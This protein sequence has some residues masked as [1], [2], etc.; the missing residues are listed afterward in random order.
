MLTGQARQAGDTVNAV[1]DNALVT[2][3]RFPSLT[4][5]LPLGPTTYYFRN[6]FEFDGDPERATLLLSPLADDGAVYYL[7]GVEIY[8]QNMPLGAVTSSTSAIRTFVA[9]SSSP[10]F[11]LSL[12]VWIL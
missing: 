2:Q 3:S 8:R 4:T 10:S 7:N 5:E 12:S 9:S 6:D 11:S 1:F